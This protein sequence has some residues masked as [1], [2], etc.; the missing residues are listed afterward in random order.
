MIVLWGI[1]EERPMAAVRAVLADERAPIFVLDQR[2]IMELSLEMTVGATVEGRL[3]GPA[4]SVDL[5]DITAIYARPY[6]PTM[7]PSIARADAASHPRQ[8]AIALHQGFRAFTEL[9][10]ALVLNRIAA[11]GANSSKPYQLAMVRALGFSVPETLVTTDP[12]VARVFLDEQR[13][14]IYK[15]ISDVRSVVS[16]VTADQ[17]GRLDAITGCPTQFQAYVPGTDIRVHVVGDRVFPC[18]VESDAVDYRYPDGRQVRRRATT[19]P[20][21]IAERCVTGAHGMGLPLA[22]I[23]LRLTP[24]GEWYCFEVNPSPAFSFF[25]LDGEIARAVA[26][27]LRSGG[28]S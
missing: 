17:R 23:D 20:D 8:H 16:R 28:P 1:A 19:L 11:M 18:E 2:A 4:G 27:L 5:S 13:D 22:G 24:N 15:S 21:E 14:V 10:R 7:I 25:D 6:D 9:T 3:I 12:Q 26:A